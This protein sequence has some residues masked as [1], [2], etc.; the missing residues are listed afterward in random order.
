MNK[1]KTIS[2]Q[3]L[4]VLAVCL[5]IGGAVK[6]IDVADRKYAQVATV[7]E[8]GATCNL[9]QADKDEE[10]FGG[11]VNLG[12]RDFPD[13]I[14]VDGTEVIDGDGNIS[15]TITGPDNLVTVTGSITAGA[16]SSVYLVKG[17]TAGGTIT[18]PP[19]AAAAGMS[20]R[21]QIG[22]TFAT[23]NV[24]IDSAEGDN[25]EGTLIV[26]GA[27]VDCNAVDQIDF[28]NDGEN[29]GDYVEFMSD[30]AQWLIGDSGALTA[31]K[32]TCTDPS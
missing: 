13:G 26:A 16:E 2:I 17:A 15:G 29:I 10:S 1:L 19:V 6:A 3:A 7:C 11:L 22:G 12:Q 5:I 20:Y 32:L 24:V 14:A 28:V 30:G 9:Y 27:V 23:N 4:G 25:I 8:A 18:L 31:S 21:V